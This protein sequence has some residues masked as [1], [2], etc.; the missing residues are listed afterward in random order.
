MVIRLDHN[1]NLHLTFLNC[2]QFADDTTL[3][4]SH[5]NLNYTKISAP[6]STFTSIF[7]SFAWHFDSNIG[8][9]LLSLLVLGNAIILCT[10]K[11]ENLLIV[12]CT[13][14]LCVLW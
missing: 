12:K 11:Q 9:V 13:C 14:F 3:Y 4:V 7:A 6:G 8:N 10:T 1:L 2:I 5:S